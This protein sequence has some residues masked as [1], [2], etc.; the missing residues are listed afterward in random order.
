MP[1]S[2]I[3]RLVPLASAA[4]ARGVHVHY[5]N[6][7]QPDIVTPDAFWQGVHGYKQKTLGYSQSPGRE[8]LK[9][10]AVADY[11][12]RGIDVKESDLVVTVGGSEAC[13]FA[14][15]SC[16]NPGDEVIVLEPYY[17]NYQ[18]FAVQTGVKLKALTAYLEDDFAL[19]PVDRIE[20]AI[21]PNTKGI[22]LCNPSNPTGCSFSNTHLHA[23]AEVA[24]K[25]NLFLIVDEV[26]RD[27]NYTDTEV[28]SCL[29][30]P[31]LEEHAVMID[32]LSKRLSLC[33]ARVGFLVSR[34]KA[35]MSGAVKLSMARLSAGT[36][37]QAG[38]AVALNNTPPEYMAQV[39]EEYRR[40]KD[41][42]VKGLAAIPGVKCP[43]IDG[44]FY[45]FFELPVEDAEDFCSWMLT[46]FNHNGETLLMAPG[47]GF[48]LT[49]GL[50]RNQ[51]RIAYVLETEKLER[52]V[53][54]L[55]HGLA[56]YAERPAEAAAARS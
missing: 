49:P 23:I 14:F 43:R 46:S 37:D 19:P 42:L 32:S 1:A 26:Y 25:K 48:Y 21:G 3:R 11:Q 17:A 52:A 53:E 5:V 54:C 4:E 22:L 27:F 55:K 34:N 40:R 12:R 44:A 41:A 8:E 16:F 56:A 6:I 38:A 7:G 45:A 35:V 15:L 18:G 31:G 20:A 36:L 2:P 10:A 29:T 47:E 39:R 51:V 50:G 9:A 28:Q 30:I 13:L 33:G 24:K